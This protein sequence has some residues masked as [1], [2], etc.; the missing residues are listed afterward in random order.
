MKI[1]VDSWTIPYSV[2]RYFHVLNVSD[3]DDISGQLLS[4]NEF[5]DTIIFRIC[6]SKV[7]AKVD[8][9]PSVAACHCLIACC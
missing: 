9:A 3:D 2:Q 7:S 4:G 6:S 5:S 8:S 1:L